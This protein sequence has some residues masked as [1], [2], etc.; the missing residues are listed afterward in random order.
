[1]KRRALLPHLSLD[2]ASRESLHSQL[3]RALRAALDTGGLS[4]GT[5]LMSTRALAASLGVSRN[6]VVT[7][8]DE[9][10]AEGRIAGRP[11]SATM[12]VNGAPPPN[13]NGVIR[14]SQYP[15][16]AARLVD[17]DRHGL[18]FDR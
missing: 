8:Y 13:W 11:G 5:T 3:A 1:M 18:Y 12:V 16:D 6:T 7:A 15:I 17:P 2:R 10:A 9:L 14:V 4:P